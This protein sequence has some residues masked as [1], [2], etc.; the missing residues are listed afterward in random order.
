MSSDIWY[1]NLLLT[2][3]PCPLE[4]V[5]KLSQ[6]LQI[7]ADLL[8][9][10]GQWPHLE[11]IIKLGE[12]IAHTCQNQ[13]LSAI[14]KM[15]R[16]SYLF[17]QQDY[18]QAKILIGESIQILESLADWPGLAKALNVLAQ[19]YTST[20]D[21]EQALQANHR[22][23]KILKQLDD[24]SG[25]IATLHNLGWIYSWINQT[26]LA[27]E[28][29]HQAAVH[30]KKHHRIDWLAA[31]YGMIAQVYLAQGKDDMGLKFLRKAQRLVIKIQ[32]VNAML[33]IIETF[34]LYYERIGD[35]ATALAY[36]QDRADFARQMGKPVDRAHSLMRIGLMYGNHCEDYDTAIPYYEQA[37]EIMSGLA[38]SHLY[39]QFLAVYAEALYFR[40][41]YDRAIEI[42]RL[43]FQKAAELNFHQSQFNSQ[44]TLAKVMA[45]RQE[46]DPC[47]KLLQAMLDET[48]DTFEQAVLHRVMYES[49]VK[50][51]INRH[52][53]IELYRQL[54]EK[55][56][57]VAYQDRLRELSADPDNHIS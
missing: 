57:Q 15:M 49:G 31:N 9:R 52:K 53:A 12:N 33:T 54:Y 41:N 39:C 14:T 42:C 20:R 21:F 5:L 11:K 28:C 22:Q 43:T 34:G 38:N 37:L 10:T 13:N 47:E 23:L 55:T 1:E 25:Q 29:F 8:L 46:L 26:E 3:T 16:A 2:N 36:Y 44:L 18:P 30:N 17:N 45:A 7:Q 24:E 19:V 6:I 51:E 27:L 35:L 4:C 32:D 48:T 40:K 56:G 50:K